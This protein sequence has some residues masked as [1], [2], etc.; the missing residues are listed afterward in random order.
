MIQLR[1]VVTDKTS[2]KAPVLQWRCRKQ[3]SRGLWTLWDD[4]QDVP[5]TVLSTERKKEAEEPI[6]QYYYHG[7][8]CKATSLIDPKCICWY[9]MGTG[10]CK[11]LVHT[12]DE[13]TGFTWRVKPT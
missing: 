13:V 6:F 5:T 10:P 9:D 2:K 11:D 1:W 12:Q 8:Q 3:D 4:W 7:P